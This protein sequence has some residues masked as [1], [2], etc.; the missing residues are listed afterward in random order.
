MPLM[1]CVH[2]RTYLGAEEDGGRN[3]TYLQLR[4]RLHTDRHAS[5]HT[6]HTPLRAL[7]HCLQGKSVTLGLCSQAGVYR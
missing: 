3:A 5:H 7:Q 6:L 4:P 1:S 2:D